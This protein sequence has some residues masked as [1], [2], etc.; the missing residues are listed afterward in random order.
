MIADQELVTVFVPDEPTQLA[1]VE[2]V[3]REHEIPF[4]ARNSEVQNLFGAGEIGAGNF[5]V[6]PVEI[7]VSGA[8]AGRAQALISEATGAAASRP[9]VAV[10]EGRSPIEE[11]CFRYSRYSLVW[12]VLW[13]GG[14]GSL[15]AVYF[16]LKALALRRQVPDLSVRRAKFGL[17][18]GVIGLIYGTVWIFLRLSG[19]A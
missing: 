19:G 14:V 4:A 6:G 5:A 15:L 7:Q 16:G 11:E 1:L 3:L 18:L 2:S 13:F 17:A 10:G 8:D 9:A 12:S